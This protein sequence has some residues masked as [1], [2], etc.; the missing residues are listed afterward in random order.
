M[1]RRLVRLGIVL[2][3]FAGAGLVVTLEKRVTLVVDGQSHFVRTTSFS[4][5]QLLARRGIELGPLDLVEPESSTVLHE[6]LQIEVRR[7]ARLRLVVNGREKLVPVP[8]GT[9]SIRDVLEEARVPVDR[10]DLVEPGLDVP[11]LHGM[12][13][14]ITRVTYRTESAV[15]VVPFPT[16]TVYDQSMRVGT[17]R[18]DQEG[19][20]GHEVVTY[21]I[22]TEAGREV[23]REVVHTQMF[24]VPQEEQVV[25]GTDARE[26]VATWQQGQASWYERPASWSSRSGL[27]AAHRWL[28]KG[29]VVQVTSLDTGE[30]ITVII[31]DR[32]P[33]GVAGRIIDLSR[34]AFE[35]LAPLGQGVLRVHLS[36]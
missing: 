33:Y 1:V 34:E 5:G 30:R 23:E 31:D 24:E 16:V 6:G 26:R 19:V 29:T 2:A 4:V 10:D 18:V 14:R 32:G 27:R 3:L 7:A 17:S 12:T 15:E 8:V 25:V 36:W 13:V 9:P 20:N 11:H 21:R 28:P 22:R 35:Q